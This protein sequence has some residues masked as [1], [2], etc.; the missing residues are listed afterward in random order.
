[1]KDF[2]TVI[3]TIGKRSA[4]GHLLPGIVVAWIFLPIFR[5]I[6][7]NPI[8][9][10]QL[11]IPDSETARW[12]G[13]LIVAWVAGSFLML[14]GSWL[15]KPVYDGFY[16]RIVKHGKNDLLEKAKITVHRDLPG[17]TCWER[18]DYFNYCFSYVTTHGPER[19]IEE[20]N[21]YIGNSKMF[22]SFSATLLVLSA[23]LIL[24]GEISYASALL[25]LSIISLWVFCYNR[26]NS[27]QRVYEYYI[28]TRATKD[29]NPGG[30]ATV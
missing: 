16:K 14:L 3:A 23:A 8:I 22:R 12:I 5:D 9:Q 7:A 2:G 13:F 19:G 6:L 26:W 24:S 10:G 18:F 28:I 25:F 20:I 30:K 17:D 11:L 1:M 21:D 15:D 27:T 29:E 4:L